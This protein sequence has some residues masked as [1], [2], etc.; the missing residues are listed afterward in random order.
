MASNY[1]KLLDRVNDSDMR[2][3]LKL[4]EFRIRSM[5]LTPKSIDVY[6]ERLGYFARFLDERSVSL[7]DVT[8]NTI[9]SYLM[10]WLDR[11]LSPHSVNGQVRV[12]RTLFIN[13][14]RAC[15]KIVALVYLS[16]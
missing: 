15:E 2:D 10:S 9:R 5:N 4:F 13:A 7:S 1:H 3:A 12:L 16:S 8:A 11:G 6:A 14:D